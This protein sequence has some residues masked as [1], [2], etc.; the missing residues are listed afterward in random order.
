MHNT[1]SHPALTHN[2]HKHTQQEKSL[3]YDAK[4]YFTPDG[5]YIHEAERTNGVYEYLC[6][7][8]IEQQTRERSR[9]R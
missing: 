1:H 6:K 5:E 7:S 8:V 3:K 2:T 9:S 4:Y